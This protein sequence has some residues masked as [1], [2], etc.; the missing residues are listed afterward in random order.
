MKKHILVICLLLSVVLSFSSC[1]GKGYDF[2]EVSDAFAYEAEY[3]ILTSKEKVDDLN[4]LSV[5]SKYSNSNFNNRISSKNYIIKT[6]FHQYL[7]PF[8]EGHFV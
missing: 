4:K 3:E 7:Q 2:A 6:N 5:Y 8:A 1:K